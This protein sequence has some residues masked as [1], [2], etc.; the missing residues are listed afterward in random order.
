MEWQ[1]GRT[2]ALTPV[3]HLHP[4]NIDGVMVA[5]ATLHNADYIREKNLL[6]GDIVTLERSGDVI[7]KILFPLLEKRTGQESQIEIPSVCPACNEKVVQ[8]KEYFFIMHQ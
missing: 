1:V 8:K 7:P 6:I 2:G 5:R 3:A 4:V